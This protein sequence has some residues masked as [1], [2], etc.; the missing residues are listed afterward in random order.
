[1]RTFCSPSPVF[2]CPV[3]PL[4]EQST[5]RE[6][7]RESKNV[8]YRMRETEREGGRHFTS[9]D[10]LPSSSVSWRLFVRRIL[11]YT[12]GTRM[13]DITKP[14][15]RRKNR[16]R[17]LFTAYYYLDQGTAQSELRAFQALVAPCASGQNTLLLAKRRNC[18]SFHKTSS[19]LVSLSFSFFLQ[20][21]RLQRREIGQIT[22]KISQRRQRPLYP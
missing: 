12:E 22:R 4:K 16:P 2:L 21:L 11:L 13:D 1:M 9:S 17:L 15:E 10:I 19:A 3:P 18:L 8:K 14:Y 7:E 6:R 20:T 5:E